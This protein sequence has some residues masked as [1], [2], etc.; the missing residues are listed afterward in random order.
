MEE[1]ELEAVEKGDLLISMY[2]N[3]FRSIIYTLHPSG[4]PGEI[5]GKASNVLWASTQMFLKR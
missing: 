3:Q 5:R 2:S 4:L 1:S